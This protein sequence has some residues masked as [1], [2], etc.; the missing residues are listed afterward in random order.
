[1]A[2]ERRMIL[3][4]PKEKRDDRAFRRRRKLDFLIF[5]NGFDFAHH[6]VDSTWL[7]TASA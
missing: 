5:A 6:G 3:V 2:A 7:T 4:I 1:M